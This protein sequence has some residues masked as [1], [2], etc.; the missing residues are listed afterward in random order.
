[1]HLLRIAV[2][3]AAIAGALERDSEARAVWSKRREMASWAL[4]STWSKGTPSASRRRI[5]LAGSPGRPCKD[6]AI[7]MTCHGGWFSK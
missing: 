7:Q 4:C 2:A 6:P 5:D 3:A 1:M